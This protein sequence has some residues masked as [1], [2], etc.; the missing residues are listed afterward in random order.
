MSEATFTKVHQCFSYLLDPT[1]DQRALLASHTGA[2]RFCHN[3]LLGIVLAKWKENREKKDTGSTSPTSRS[4]SAR[5]SR[6]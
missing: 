5:S 2:A 1:P 3:F 6:G 4:S